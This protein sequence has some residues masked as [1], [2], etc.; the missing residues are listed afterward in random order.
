MDRLNAVLMTSLIAVAA[1]AFAQ[2]SSARISAD[3]LSFYDVPLAC[4]AAR[5]LG[6][7]SAPRPVLQALEKKSSIQEAWLDHAGRFTACQR[8]AATLLP[9]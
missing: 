3:Q 7:G 9:R 2:T 5:G 4:P 6:C 8:A 1:V